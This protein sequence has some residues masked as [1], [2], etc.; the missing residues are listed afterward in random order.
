MTAY[1]SSRLALL[2]AG[3]ASAAAA[4]TAFA[5]DDA[6]AAFRGLAEKTIVERTLTLRELGLTDPIVLRSFDSRREIYIPAPAGLPLIDPTLQFKGRYLRAD[7]GRTTFVLSV[8]GYPVAARAPNLDAGGVDILL[9]VDGA[10]RPS[11]FVRLGA[12]W[13]SAID[14]ELCGDQ[15]SIG[16]V[17]QI[18]ADT[19]LTFSFDA[20]KIDSLVTAWSAM[21]VTPVLLVPG[22]TLSAESYDAAWR[23]ALA[24]ERAGKRPTIIALPAVGDE[25]ELAR[26]KIPAG[27]AGLPSFA[28]LKGEG[29]HRLASPGEV[30]AFVAL[31]G[32]T[33]QVAVSDAAMNAS[34]AAALDA[35]AAEA[36]AAGAQDAFGRWR[37][38]AMTLAVPQPRDA[39]A[40][41][42]FAGAPIGAVGVD[43]APKAAD[44]F[45]AYWRDVLISRKLAIRAA[46]LPGREERV[47]SLAALGG[48]PKSLD[49]VSSAD[50]TANFD[51]GA[52]ATY[53]GAPR[54]LLID[55]A[56]A[57]GAST[58]DPVASVFLN[59][60][61]LAARRLTANGQPERI[62][63]TV[64]SFALRAVNTLKVSFQ[65]QPV[66]DRCRDTPQ[67]FPVAVL[68]SSAARLGPL[69]DDSGFLGVRARLGGGADLI[70]P[71]TFLSDAPA[72]LANVE[73][74]AAAAG[75]SPQNATLVVAPAQPGAAPP[76]AA[77][78]S[79]PF[80]A[81]DV[82]LPQG[83]SSPHVMVD[84]DRL[85][86][87]ARPGETLLD[88]SG[89]G[90]LAVAEVAQVGSVA[91]V[92]VQQ[93]GAEPPRFEE[94][95]LLAEGDVAVL[96]DAGVA[97][98]FDSANP[99]AVKAADTQS[100]EGLTRGLKAFA[101]WET[102]A[103]VGAIVFFGVLFLLAR[104]ARRRSR[105]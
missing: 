104:A 1:S 105:D 26:L 74:L 63:A 94:P 13:A 11:G 58:S 17:F 72:T 59:D 40:L 60:F 79:K 88:I 4:S 92:S 23:L 39:I 46:E 81:I 68:P 15:R 36:A 102:A 78:P 31:G 96:T 90:R 91:G 80:L 62:T 77:P 53:G 9:G 33:A 48:V 61:L 66:S 103:V 16:N 12:A 20:S 57:P 5:A 35:L 65:R 73:R 76:T 64:P 25:V 49:A 51:L 83:A 21:S 30:G 86:L 54:E 37:E 71:S 42:T 2:L 7:G 98:H 97:A 38:R 19:S 45:S 75:L 101:N 10:P 52:V 47:V 14:T 99:G 89:V 69:P 41:A 28:A 44:L 3:L 22:R 6:A 24:L 55:V 70:I 67:P 43:A 87:S 32:A 100:P 84:G 18:D 27:L 95:F 50:W 8:D 85:K 29:R 34:L 93:V 82:A 56:A